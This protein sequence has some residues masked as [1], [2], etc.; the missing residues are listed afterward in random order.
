[1]SGI[2]A[3]VFWKDGLFQ[4]EMLQA[5]ELNPVRTIPCGILS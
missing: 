3:Y 5:G 1:M 2:A 4:T